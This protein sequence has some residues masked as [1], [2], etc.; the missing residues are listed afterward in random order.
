MNKINNL[1]NFLK[2][3]GHLLEAE[4]LRRI[5][6]KAIT[7][8]Q[9]NSHSLGWLDPN[10]KFHLLPSDIMKDPVS[11]E[12]WIE[13]NLNVNYFD[14]K[15]SKDSLGWI[16][17]SDSKQYYSLGRE[18][19][20]SDRIEVAKIFLHCMYDGSN[21]SYIQHQ[22]KDGATANFI[23]GIRNPD[24][25]RYS[26][27]KISFIDFFDKIARESELGQE[28]QEI[29]Y[30]MIDI[31]TYEEKPLRDYLSQD[32]LDSFIKLMPEEHVVYGE[33]GEDDLLLDDVEFFKKKE[34]IPPHIFDRIADRVARH[35]DANSFFHNSQYIPSN[36]IDNNAEKKASELKAS[37]LL[38]F[39]YDYSQPKIPK[40]I[41]EKLIVERATELSDWWVE[42][43]KEYMSEDLYSKI[44]ENKNIN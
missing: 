1:Y 19:N 7:N 38:S 35:M 32:Q 41:F 42:E 31:D 5:I 11:H 4:L 13:E 44:I 17:V 23:F 3:E 12:S 14:W 29:F 37:D 20:A 27:S 22:L 2:K 34:I 40:E 16:K 25:D 15:K 6:K 43:Y 28:L 10:S 24:N 21:L 39:Y 9:C 30:K 36:I 33:Y 18:F 26:Y 8:Y